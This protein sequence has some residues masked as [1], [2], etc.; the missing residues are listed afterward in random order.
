MKMP[1]AKKVQFGMLA[2]AAWVIV[3]QGAVAGEITG[4]GK[5]IAGSPE[6]PLKGKSVCAF[7]GQQDDPNEPG[8][9]GMITQSWG[10]MPKLVRDFLTL[11]GASPGTSCNPTKASGSEP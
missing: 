6:A 10:Q 2:C 1:A 11:I 7:S 3:G 9:K 5:W 4:N 8:F